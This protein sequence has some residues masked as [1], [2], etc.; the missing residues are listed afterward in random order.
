VFQS[1]PENSQRSSKQKG[2]CLKANVRSSLV[3]LAVG[4]STAIASADSI[5][6]T[7]TGAVNVAG[8]SQWTYDLSFINS[9]LN[10]GDF[11]TINDFGAGAPIAVPA[12][13]AYSQSLVGPNSLPANDDPGLLNATFTWIGNSGTIVSPN[14]TTVANQILTLSS[15]EALG[16][17]DTSDYTTIDHVT[18]G[19]VAGT[20]S[21]VI[22]TVRTP[23]ATPKAVPDTGSTLALFGMAL[24][25]VECARR[26]ISR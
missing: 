22:G 3:L 23:V 12:G 13:W 19:L 10:T 11:V 26:K 9:T 8:G 4:V 25:M 5:T 6:V 1:Q 17:L 24:T 15:P 2:N 7:E 21:R 18:S 20:P 16:S 14:S